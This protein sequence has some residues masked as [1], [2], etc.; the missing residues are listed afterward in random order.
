VV[1]VSVGDRKTTSGTTSAQSFRPRILQNKC[2]SVC[3][4]SESAL[5]RQLKLEH[6]VEAGPHRLLLADPSGARFVRLGPR[7]AQNIVRNHGITHQTQP[8]DGREIVEPNRGYISRDGDA[9]EPAQNNPS[10]AQCLPH[11]TNTRDCLGEE[12]ILQVLGVRF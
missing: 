8:L 4:M 7:N 1:I 3:A 10:F 6:S 5:L 11:R 12:A 2:E 9:E